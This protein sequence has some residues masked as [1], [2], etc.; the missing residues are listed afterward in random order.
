MLCN[1]TGY[2]NNLLAVPYNAKNFRIGANLK[3][4]NHILLGIIRKQTND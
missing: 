1:T 3:R 2:L 4:L